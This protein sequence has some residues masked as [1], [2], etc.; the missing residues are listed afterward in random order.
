MNGPP[1]ILTTSLKNVFKVGSVK[2]A[3]SKYAPEVKAALGLKRCRANV[4]G[5][6]N[7]A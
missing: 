4:K 7:P 1:K 3:N 2:L 6:N 5:V